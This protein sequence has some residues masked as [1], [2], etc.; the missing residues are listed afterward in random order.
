MNKRLLSIFC[1]LVLLV[2]LTPVS[3]AYDLGYTPETPLATLQMDGE[4]TDYYSDLSGHQSD[5]DILLDLFRRTKGQ[6]AQITLHKEVKVN[7]SLVID[8]PDTCLTLELDSYGVDLYCTNH[9]VPLFKVTAG[10]LTLKGNGEFGASQGVYISGDNAKVVLNGT[11]IMPYAD[12]T[13][14]VGVGL[15]GS[16]SL[17]II[18]SHIGNLAIEENYQTGVLIQGGSASECSAVIDLS[19][20]FAISGHTGISVEHGGSLVIKG[21]GRIVSNT[22]ISNGI[23]LKADQHS[24]VT[25][26]GGRYMSTG[27]NGIAIK[28]EYPIGKMLVDGYAFYDY[29][30]GMPLKDINVNDTSSSNSNDLLV[31][32]VDE[33]GPVAMVTMADGHMEQFFSSDYQGSDSA[34]LMAAWEY[35]DNGGASRLTL[36]RNIEYNASSPLQL[37]YYN[38]DLTI[39]IPD[40]ITLT[41]AARS[42]E[43]IQVTSGRLNIGNGTIVSKGGQTAIRVVAGELN[44]SGGGITTDCSG[45]SSIASTIEANSLASV[46]ISGGEISLTNSERTES[47]CLAADAGSRVTLSGGAFTSNQAAIEADDTVASLLAPGYYFYLETDDGTQFVDL[48][49]HELILGE[50][51]GR[52]VVELGNAGEL[53]ATVVTDDGSKKE[54]FTLGESGTEADALARA[55]AYAEGKT[56][57]LTVHRG[58]ELSRALELYSGSTK[59]ELCMDSGAYISLD[60]AQDG[61]IRV[62][63]G[64]LE[65]A[66]GSIRTS[67]EKAIGL[68]MNG[69]CRVT[70]SGGEVNAGT[71]SGSSAVRLGDDAELVVTGGKLLG[72]RGVYLERSTYPGALLLSGSADVYGSDCGVYAEGGYIGFSD[73]LV[74]SGHIGIYL[75]EDAGLD[76]NGDASIAVNGSGNTV[77]VQIE[78]GVIANI[79]GS[80]S[81]VAHTSGSG[82]SHG[83]DQAAGELSVGGRASISASSYSSTAYAAF[84]TGGIAAISGGSF[85][86]T[87]TNSGTGHGLGVGLNESTVELSG[88]SFTSTEDGKAV[89]AFADGDN[90]GRLL[91]SG[92]S[93][94]D[95]QNNRVENPGELQS[96][97]G[98]TSYTVKLTEA[99]GD[100]VATLEVNGEATN[101]TLSKPGDTVKS[102]FTA[103]LAGA[104][105]KTATLT[106]MKSAAPDSAVTIGKDTNLT[107]VMPEDVQ[108]TANV[109]VEGTL[110]LAGGKIYSEYDQFTSTGTSVVTVKS[111]GCLNVLSGQIDYLLSEGASGSEFSAVSVEAGGAVNISGGAIGYEVYGLVT[112]KSPSA[113]TISGGTVNM[114]GGKVSA[115]NSSSAASNNTAYAIKLTDG[116]FNM[117]SGMVQAEDGGYEGNSMTALSVQDGKADLSGGS[118]ES[119]AQGIHMAGGSAYIGGS[120]ELRA[121]NGAGVLVSDGSLEVYGNAFIQGS[122]IGVELKNSATGTHGSAN[123]Y[124]NAKIT[125]G[126]YGMYVDSHSKATVNDMPVFTGT[127]GL[128]VE[129]IREKNVNLYG[130]CYIG[131]DAE[132]G[133][134]RV[135][136]EYHKYD[137]DDWNYYDVSSLLATNYQFYNSQGGHAMNLTV[138]IGE[139]ICTVKSEN[140][141]SELEG[142]VSISGNLTYGETLTAEIT[143]LSPDTAVLTYKWYRCDDGRGSGAALVGSGK[144]YQLTA[145]D[146]GKYI[147][148]TVTAADLSGSL[149]DITAAAVE[150]ADNPNKPTGLTAVDGTGVKDG[151]IT[152][153][154]SAMEYADNANF[155]GAKNC[156]DSEITGLAGGEYYVR[157]KETATHKAG[158]AVAIFVGTKTAIETLTVNGVTI[159]EDYE[160]N[161][162]ASVQNLSFDPVNSILTAHGAEINAEQF[163]LTGS[164]TLRFTGTQNKITGLSENIVP[165]GELSIQGTGSLT[166]ERDAGSLVYETVGELTVGGRAYRFYGSVNGGWAGIVYE[167]NKGTVSGNYAL[168]SAAATINAGDTLTIP[169]GA[170]LTNNI[171]LTNNGTLII[172]DMDSIAGSGSIVGG[173]NIILDPGAAMLEI[174]TPDNAVFDGSTDYAQQVSLGLK[175]KIVIQG[176]E[177]SFDAS[178]WTRRITR[179]GEVVS[180]AV[181]DGV[182]I[183]TYSRD[184][185]TIGPVSFSVTRI[186]LPDTITYPI[187]VVS[188]EHGSVSASVNWAEAGSKVTLT[189]T[190]DDGWKLDSL[191]ATD[192]KGG[193]LSLTDLGGGKYSFTMPSAKVTVKAVFTSGAAPVFSDV[194]AGSWYYDAVAYVS[195]NGLM[196]GV[197]A[198]TFDPNGTLTRAM[199][200]TILA[201]LEGVDTEGGASWYAKA[202][203]WAMESGVS[204]GDDPMGTITREQLV[205]MLWRY[206]GA[207]GVEFLLT[208]PDA[209]K[210]SSWA[211]DAMRWAVSEGIIEGDE[212]GAV[213]PTGSATRAE[214]AAIFMRFAEGLEK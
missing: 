50:G 66:S 134:V 164:V 57:T 139:Q 74:S 38:S 98:S 130:G 172:E 1:I 89:L 49:G 76:M 189:V 197:D 26:S 192:A 128:Y 61:V 12:G 118:I 54:E 25:L 34:A 77:G 103:A 10:S 44:I 81:I 60:N 191:S 102:L 114:R 87:T 206:S 199:V 20:N 17:Q 200:W 196:N 85:T 37:N 163:E 137:I 15:Y 117:T 181:S 145:A 88:G 8:D 93:Y 55:F 106:L 183:V 111:G 82:T 115:V 96:L 159:V 83:I 152:G 35:A 166:L 4:T 161:Q 175:D 194:P 148:V 91:K 40:G 63:D 16:G 187:E 158:P 195:E 122:T 53:V 142:E 68:Y 126:D 84:L 151:K 125:G 94:Y 136:E 132:S 180:S 208:A 138:R 14:T 7:T 41:G 30:S 33:K 19:E 51:G 100:L 112:G 186:E 154:T 198:G 46:N 109:V 170:V 131:A 64:E 108:L 86:G 92:Y 104:N 69:S 29:S 80:A 47:V 209:G 18:N 72:Q 6:T 62:L 156:T 207:P 67:G 184:G 182:Y 211:M 205:T 155:A 150:K 21:N 36:Q 121:D 193:K 95:S 45:Y 124:G 23:A 178:A 42:S 123:I 149:K 169:E 185:A 101:Y 75:T 11:S 212:T 204:D 78:Y 129:T 133:S 153:V 43:L 3:A 52:Y 190:P 176:A 165:G 127:N 58:V 32:T 214:A 71:A 141:S 173:T 160:Y 39:N 116:E 24:S 70:V 201:R 174:S 202:Q 97:S 73:G 65:L 90:V 143:G 157:F 179:N 28:S 13:S 110:G 210:I 119:N 99:S 27:T 188:T 167:G 22:Q 147:S 171:T 105:G 9:S 144:T 146:I 31:K 168:C 162:S 48:N 5:Q 213:N 120:A 2:S 140:A 135:W 177:F 107:L 113:L 59:L 56:S 203:A 79:G